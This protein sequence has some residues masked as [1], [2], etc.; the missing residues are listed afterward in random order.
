[1]NAKNGGG[2]GEV[3]PRLEVE[4]VGVVCAITRLVKWL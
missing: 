3:R 4:N 1:M 2:C